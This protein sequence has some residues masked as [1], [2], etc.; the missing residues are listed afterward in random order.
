MA[1]TT[2]MLG[3]E[4]FFDIVFGF[5][6]QHLIR[7]DDWDDRTAAVFEG[8][9]NSLKQPN[10]FASENMFVAHAMVPEAS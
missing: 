6:Q 9:R 7:M 3:A 2:Q 10:A 4:T 1:I 5:K 8:I